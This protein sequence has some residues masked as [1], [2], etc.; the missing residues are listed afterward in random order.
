[1]SRI[2]GPNAIVCVCNSTYCDAYRRPQLQADQFQMYT[3]TMNGERLRLTIGNFSA[4]SVN[5]TLFTV[6]SKQIYQR[7]LGFGGALTDA[8]SLNIRTLSNATQQ[9]LL[10]YVIDIIN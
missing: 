7:I 6:D 2:V 4:E 5:G 9:N 1:M 8:V 10:K 3:S